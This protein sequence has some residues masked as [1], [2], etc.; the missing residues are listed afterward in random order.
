M[1]FSTVLRKFIVSGAKPPEESS[2][3]NEEG[4][5]CETFNFRESGRRDLQL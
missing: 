4:L 2:L 1:H 5:V 3:P